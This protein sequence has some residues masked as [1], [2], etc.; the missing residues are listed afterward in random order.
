MHPTSLITGR[1][2]LNMLLP[3]ALAQARA[4]SPELAR[5]LRRI[6]PRHRTT[7]APAGGGHAERARRVRQIQAGSLTAANGLTPTYTGDHP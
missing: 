3:H 5:H 2:P 7:W 6:A 4:A 1:F